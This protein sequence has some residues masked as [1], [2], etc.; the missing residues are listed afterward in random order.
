MFRTIF[1][2]ARTLRLDMLFFSVPYA[3]VWARALGASTDGLAAS[4]PL[5]L[6]AHAA[7]LLLA[8]LLSDTREAEAGREPRLMLWRDR[9]VLDA[10]AQ[11]GGVPVLALIASVLTL[12]LLVV[13]PAAGL[14]M[15][16]GAAVLLWHGTRAMRRKYVLIELAAPAL[17]LAVPGLL[18][19]TRLLSRARDMYVGEMDD[20]AAPTAHALAAQAAVHPVLGASLLGAVALGL[21]V[22]LCL[23]RDAPM[24]ESEGVGSVAAAVGRPGARALAWVWAVAAVLLASMGAGW[25]WWGWGVAAAL[26]VG[27]MGVASCLASGAYGRAVSVW[28]AL[29]AVAAAALVFTAH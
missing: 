23:L 11:S 28:A 26:G 21:F 14:Y 22:M 18:V 19:A 5:I 8:L 25:Q 9:F 4:G 7:L 2:A 29:H 15:I 3:F 16:L 17:V 12:V 1:Y 6:G 20:V 10:D 13:D 27:S 24:D